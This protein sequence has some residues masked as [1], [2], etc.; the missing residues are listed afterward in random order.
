MEL[1]L[2]DV[3]T[4]VFIGICNEHRRL[5]HLEPK[6]LSPPCTLNISYKYL[7]LSL[8]ALSSDLLLLSGGIPPKTPRRTSRASRDQ[9]LRRPLPPT[10]LR[11]LHPPGTLPSLSHMVREALRR[12]SRHR[13]EGN[14][15]CRKLEREQRG[16]DD[17]CRGKIVVVSWKMG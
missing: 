1:F 11:P 12:N 3:P 7:T 10:R 9:H 5:V 16:R 15:H 17:D 13:G 8:L 6:I 14:E 2:C 4:Y